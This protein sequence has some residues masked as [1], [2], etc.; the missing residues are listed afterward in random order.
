MNIRRK[1]P[2]IVAALLAAG[3]AV[4]G[5]AMARG[6]CAEAPRAE[7]AQKMSMMQERHAARMDGHFDALADRLALRDEQRAAWQSFRESVT[8][9]RGQHSHRFGRDDNPSAAARMQ[10]MEEAAEARLERIRAMRVAAEALYAQLDET[11]RKVFD[12]HRPGVHDGG[13]GKH[14]QRHSG[15]HG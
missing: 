6:D 4:A 13:H 7:R 1:S 5:T 12:E 9:G 14:H 11:Q 15:R 10:R 8:Q 2:F 3:V